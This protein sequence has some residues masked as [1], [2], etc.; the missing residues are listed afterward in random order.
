MIDTATNNVIDYIV[1]GDGPSAVAV[2]PNGSLVYV[3]SNQDNTVLVIYTG[4]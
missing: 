3:T 1:G 4:D 2:S